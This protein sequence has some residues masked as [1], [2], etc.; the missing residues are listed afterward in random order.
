MAI[1]E[2]HLAQTFIEWLKPPTTP[3]QQE[4]Q[5]KKQEEGH[6]LPLLNRLEESHEKVMVKEEEN[7]NESLQDMVTVALHIGLPESASSEGDL[8]M[9]DESEGS[10]VASGSTRFW[11]PTPSQILIGPVQFSCSVC[12][13]SF[14]RY[15]NMQVG[16]IIT[17][18]FIY[19]YATL[20]F[21][22]FVARVLINPMIIMFW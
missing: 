14:N 7:E 2:N 8:E 12:N 19:I 3:S 11:I 1:S 16:L 18:L 9:K 21:S 22:L 15:N 20:L 4:Q 17:F 10:T 13:K 5:P 6:C